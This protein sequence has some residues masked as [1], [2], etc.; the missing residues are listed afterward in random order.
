MSRKINHK[1]ELDDIRVP[2]ETELKLVDQSPAD[3]VFNGPFAR[4]QSDI[5]RLMSTATQEEYNALAKSVGVLD[6]VNF[7]DGLDDDEIAAL[8]KPRYIQSDSDIAK[9]NS[10]VSRVLHDKG[11]AMTSNS[12]PAEPVEPAEPSPSSTPSGGNQ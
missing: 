9:W 8:T 6:E 2:F 1:S 10:F 5:T 11:I 12:E 3:P 4:P 7:N